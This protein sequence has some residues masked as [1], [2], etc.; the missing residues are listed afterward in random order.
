LLSGAPAK[1][2]DALGAFGR[3]LGLAFQVFDDILDLAGDEEAMGKRKGTDLRG[4]TI[5]LPLVLALEARPDLGPRL[6]GPALDDAAV[7]AII[8][9]VRASGALEQAREYALA[10]IAAA[11][12]E[13]GQLP[14]EVDKQ[15]LGEVAGAVVDRYS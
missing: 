14:D 15:L 9:E 6:K 5:T 3:S 12:E 1:T 13:L 4:G 8:T 10:H 7:R 2:V 11:R